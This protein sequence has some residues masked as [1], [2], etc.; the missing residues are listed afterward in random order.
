MKQLVTELPTLMENPAGT[1]QST[2]MG[3]MACSYGRF[4]AGTDLAPVFEG[5]P[6]DKCPCPHWGYIL[7]GAIR[8]SYSDGR[9][10]TVRAGEAFYLSPGHAPLIL[11]DTTFV[12]FSP[13]QEYNEVLSHVGRKLQG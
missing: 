5:L 9:E 10:E 1:L 6:D 12:E 11:E 13:E 2:P 3:G 7:E 4:V 8:I